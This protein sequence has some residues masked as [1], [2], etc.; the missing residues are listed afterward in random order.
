MAGALIVC[1]DDYGAH[2]GGDAVIKDLI[3][4]G[5]L[6]ATSCLVEGAA[7]AKDAPRLRV[8]GES[9]PD[10]AIGLH[11]KLTDRPGDTVR[12]SLAPPAPAKVAEA[13]RAQLA[14]FAAVMGRAP[15]FVDGHHHV[16]LVPAVRGP[17]FEALAEAGFE[18]WL[19]QCASP[20]RR[21][22]G[23]SP[24]GTRPGA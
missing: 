3:R 17:L 22:A 19:R 14:A 2:P 21:C 16:H 11:L 15:D 20:G 18:G 24:C 8:L 13:V 6:N 4:G 23:G 7:W 9:R 5:Y 10:V 1:A 12:M